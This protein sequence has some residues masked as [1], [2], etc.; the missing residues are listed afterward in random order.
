MPYFELNKIIASILLAALVCMLAGNFADIFYAKNAKPKERGYAVVVDDS[1]AS[2][3][4]TVVEEIKLDIPAL[5][6]KASAELG[7]QVAKKC[8]ACH[9]VDKGEPN[10][11]GP[12]LWSVVGRD[13]ASISD[14]NYSKA[15]QTKGGKWDYDSLFAFLKNPSKYAPGT[16]MAFAGLAKPE[17][18]ANV[19]AF[20]RSK[21][22][23]PAP[24]SQ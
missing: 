14:Y 7:E 3:A 9:N 19:V 6:A 8:A 22:D 4:A 24:L 18:I 11:I 1:A 20:L 15:L 10:K 13:K 12:H 2:V 17:D 23:N 5:M 21:S 16:K